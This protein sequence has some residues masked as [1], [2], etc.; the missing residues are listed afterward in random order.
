[1]QVRDPAMSGDGVALRD[2]AT[3]PSDYRDSLRR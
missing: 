2:D 3:V 1:M